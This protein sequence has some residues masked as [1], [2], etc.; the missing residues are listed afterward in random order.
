MFFK[1]VHKTLNTLRSGYFLKMLLLSLLATGAGYAIFFYGIVW[2]LNS[3]IFVTIGWLEWVLD[4]LAGIGTG[5][6][7]WLLFPAIL[8][9][10]ASLFLEQI[11]GSIEKREY[12][13]AETPSLPFWPE[14]MSSLSFAGFVLFINLILLPFYLFPVL[15][16]FL[17]YPVNAYLVGREFFETCAARHMGRREA[18]ELRK[19]Y[20]FAVMLAGGALVGITNIPIANLF[21]PFLGVAI[22]VHLF[23]LLKPEAAVKASDAP[24]TPPALPPQSQSIS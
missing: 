12:G 3:T 15:I 19:S 20:R 23:L 22:M 5:I 14:L 2:A 10:I 6:L 16:P 13:M 11:A 1:A 8:P 9:V 4:W 17:Y 18:R 7:A 24:P 21:A